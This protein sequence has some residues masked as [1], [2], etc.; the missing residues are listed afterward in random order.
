M[1][2]SRIFFRYFMKSELMLTVII[3]YVSDLVI[4]FR[5]SS[6]HCL[7]QL[8][9]SRRHW[10]R[11]QKKTKE[12]EKTGKSNLKQLR[13]LIADICS[14]YNRSRI[15]SVRSIR[16]SHSTIRDK[17]FHFE[18]WIYRIY[19]NSLRHLDVEINL[20]IHHLN[21]WLHCVRRLPVS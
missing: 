7:N 8:I 9:L 14:H 4:Q 5:F 3:F 6:A 17:E 15:I 21:R 10:I 16:W 20:S 2:D 13:I 1:K 11:K 12:R 19:K 18:L